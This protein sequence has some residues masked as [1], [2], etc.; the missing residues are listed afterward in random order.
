MNFTVS[1][2]GCCASE[3]LSVFREHPRVGR[4]FCL[5][6]GAC[7]SVLLHSFSGWTHSR[8]SRKWRL[9]LFACV[10]ACICVCSSIGAASFAHGVWLDNQRLLIH[11][12]WS[13]VDRISLATSGKTVT[14]GIYC[15]ISIWME[16][17]RRKKDL[18]LLFLW[19][20]SGKLYMECI[21]NNKL[22]CTDFPPLCSCEF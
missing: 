14:I 5:G 12:F 4:A 15:E 11:H 17:K 9:V 20:M 3:V 16:E 19:A 8:D 2:L 22:L 6:D 7:F 1:S 18:V 10:R 13:T 21:D